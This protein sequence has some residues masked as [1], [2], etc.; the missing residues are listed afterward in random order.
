MRKNLLL[1]FMIFVV[2]LQTACAENQPTSI[3]ESS[4]ISVAEDP[5]IYQWDTARYDFYEIYLEEPTGFD[6]YED[7]YRIIC[8]MLLNHLDTYEFVVEEPDYGV[9]RIEEILQNDI[10][11]AYE[12]VSLLLNTYTD[13]WS[14]LT[15]ECKQMVN[16]EGEVISLTYTLILTQKDG[17]DVEE[18]KENQLLAEEACFEL[19]ETMFQDGTLTC[20][21]TEKERAYVLYQWIGENVNYDYEVS[22]EISNASI[23]DNCYSAM[24]DKC[25]VCQGITGA[26]VQLCR[27]A[28]VE[29]Y[30]Q[31][32]TTQS[33]PHSWCKLEIGDEWFYIDPTWA[34]TGAQEGEPYTDKWFFV[35]QEFMENYDGSPREFYLES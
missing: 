21:M 25:A 13:F 35:T 34:I 3:E 31:L 12:D 27:L 9:D 24:I 4:V 19:I 32:G 22:S 26:Y 11:E 14:R 6:S 10:I 30:I 8:Y 23:S 33:G 29:M 18:V 2:L 7:Y 16:E 17:M 20:E 1:L 28:G 15:A 5:E